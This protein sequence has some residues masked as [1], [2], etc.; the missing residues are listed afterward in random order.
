MKMFIQRKLYKKIKIKNKLTYKQTIKKQTRKKY[1][2]FLSN[3]KQQKI[4]KVNNSKVINIKNKQKQETNIS[5]SS[6]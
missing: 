4:I 2:F 3:K 1:F 6:F 5:S